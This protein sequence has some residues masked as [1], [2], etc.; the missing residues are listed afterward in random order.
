VD[1]PVVADAAPVEAGSIYP[2]AFQD[3]LGRG[4]D[5]IGRKLDAAFQQLFHGEA[6]NEAVYRPVGNDQAYI[7]DIRLANVRV[8]QMGS[9]MM[10]AVQ[11]NHKEEFDRLWAWA[12][13]FLLVSAGP[14]SN[15][16]HDNCDTTGANCSGVDIYG[17]SYIAT[18]LLFATGRW[19]DRSDGSDLY[20][21]D[22][23]ARLIL[24]GLLSLFD[25]RAAVG[26][27]GFVS[28]ASE[29]AVPS[30]QLP[31]F[32]AVWAVATNNPFWRRVAASQRAYW[33]ASADPNTGLIP[34]LADLTGMP[35][36]GGDVFTL[37]CY[38]L[39]M[40]LTVDHIWN[41]VDPWQV[42]EA[43]RV[44]AFFTKQGIDR[45]VDR[46]ALDGTP[47]GSTHSISLVAMNGAMA[48]SAS[49]PD[50][51]S[52]IQAVWD[53]PIPTGQSRTSDGLFYLL[54]L[55]VLSGNFRMY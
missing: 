16:F 18:A 9:A 1:S 30:S 52:F 48:L 45:Y 47:T 10:S 42:A 24:A 17:T 21:Y 8:Q 15:T 28:P 37:I 14:G 22:L 6:S 32:A 39:G 13:T 34:A 5:E 55:L 41:G 7:E 40:N 38:A 33:Q 3:I 46:Y 54:S 51:I 36:A 2:N 4:T 11:L 26:V 31:A 53:L 20:N 35:V 27:N 19:G 50:R 43:D 12:S 44:I 29:S 23:Q 49:T 25:A